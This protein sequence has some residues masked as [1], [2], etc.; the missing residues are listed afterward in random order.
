V[1]VVIVDPDEQTSAFIPRTAVEPTTLVPLLPQ[2]ESD[3]QTR[4]AISDPSG[5]AHLRKDIENLLGESA[6]GDL[7]P[8]IGDKGRL[9]ETGATHV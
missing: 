3:K 4:P 9:F 5:P 2:P 6:A 8:G 7:R 1:G